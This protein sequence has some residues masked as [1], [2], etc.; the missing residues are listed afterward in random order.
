MLVSGD[1]CSSADI[2][3]L[4]DAARH[5]P[6]SRAIPASGIFSLASMLAQRKD[7]LWYCIGSDRAMML[8]AFAVDQ[9]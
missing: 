1:L 7:A 5:R 8:L 4:I 3:N 6:F 9:R 2:T